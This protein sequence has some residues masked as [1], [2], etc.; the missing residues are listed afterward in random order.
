MH[1]SIFT[2]GDVKIFV[3]RFALMRTN[4][5]FSP[6]PEGRQQGDWRCSQKLI[7][8]EKK[9]EIDRNT[10]NNILTKTVC[11]RENVKL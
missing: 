9:K 11:H 5:H 10:I 6:I 8:E 4:D 1:I 2:G 3:G 7:F